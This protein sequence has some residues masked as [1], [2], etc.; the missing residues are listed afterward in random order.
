MAKLAKLVTH[1]VLEMSGNVQRYSVCA[2]QGDRATRY[3]V[4]TLVDGGIPYVIPDNVR[5]IV[6]VTKPDGKHVYNACSYE[7]QD[8]MIEL[9]S[10]ILAVNGIARCEVEIR[11]NDDSQVI[12]SA[13]FEIEILKNERNENAI[14][15]SDEYTELEK[16][17][18]ELITKVSLYDLD[19][20]LTL[21]GKAAD[22]AAVGEAL[23]KLK[24]ELEK[25]P[26]GM[27]VTQLELTVE[28][29]DDGSHKLII[30]DGKNQK[31]VDIPAVSITEKQLKD[32]INAWL[33]EHPDATTTIEDGSVDNSKIAQSAVTGDKVNGDVNKGNV[34]FFSEIQSEVGYINGSGVLTD[35]AGY[36][37]TDYME[38]TPLSS[39]YIRAYTNAGKMFGYAVAEYD[40][41]KKFLKMYQS[42]ELSSVT[43]DDDNVAEYTAAKNA[44]YIRVNYGSNKMSEN[45][46]QCITEKK[47]LNWLQLTENNLDSELVKKIKS[48]IG[49]KDKVTLKDIDAAITQ[50]YVESNYSWEENTALVI[51]YGTTTSATGYMVTNYIPVMAGE[52][53]RYRSYSATTVIGCIYNLNK[54][55]IANLDTGALDMEMEMPAEASYVRIMSHTSQINNFY[56]KQLQN[57]KVELPALAVNADNICD[58]SITAE[59]MS[60]DIQIPIPEGYINMLMLSDGVKDYIEGNATA[61]VNPYDGLIMC[62]V[63]DSITEGVGTTSI[64]KRWADIVVGQLS[65]Q[66]DYQNMG[67]RNTCITAVNDSDNSIVNRICSGNIAEDTD[68]ITVMG[69]VNDYASGKELGSISD[70]I[71]YYNEH[72]SWNTH[73]F[74]G[75]Y[76]AIIDYIRTYRPDAELIIMTPMHYYEEEKENT[77]GVTLMDYVNAIRDIAEYYGVYVVDVYNK[78]GVDPKNAMQRTRWTS[79][80]NQTAADGIHPNDACNARIAKL[81]V[82]ELK[83]HYVK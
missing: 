22:A 35:T 54:E 41:D 9:T 12:T 24:G 73:N 5:A 36:L 40:T 32:T 43:I 15:S 62:A 10:Q 53:I 51:Y 17:L 47:K 46:I 71:I 42:T 72:M 61:R 65:M 14:E 55:K 28:N 44:G 69:G 45:Y 6:N 76:C 66:R 48:M 74:C 26:P 29:N 4:A 60:K 13:G 83:Y 75:A 3:V 19:N 59:K 56:F 81:V 21:N 68:I 16:R 34:V 2:K 7:N 52:V 50:D 82:N 57:L 27:D 18:G 39:Y 58:R 20:S 70:A 38:V 37:C 80:V 31:N 78:L 77:A 33:S 30:S 63:G 1:I 25:L 64:D 8:V 49:V 23:E 11:T 67:L 79:N